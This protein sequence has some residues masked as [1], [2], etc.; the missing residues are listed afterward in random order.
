MNDFAVFIL[1]HGR[2][3]NVLTYATLKRLGYTGWIY[4]IVDDLDPKK[5]EYI[6][7]YG[8]EVVVFSKKEVG[9]DVGDNFNDM[10]GVVYA[11]N[12]SFDIAKDLRIQ[13][14]IQ[15]DDDYGHFQFRYDGNL[16]YNPR[17]VKDLDSV[18]AALLEFYKSAPIHSVCIA[19]GGDYIGGRESANAKGISTKRKAM[20]SF[21]CGTDRPFDFLGRINED[22]NTYVQHGAAG[23]VFLTTNQLSLE[24]TQTQLA[25]GGLTEQYLDIGTYVK[26]FYSVMYQPSSVKINVLTDRGN[27]RIHHR[28]SWKNTTP[29]ILRDTLKKPLLKNSAT[30]NAG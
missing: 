30:N 12:A 4:L 16:D 1:T 26:S 21:L 2:P 22:V 6:H 10:R 7:R 20:N 28:V 25:S 9:F 11:R 3:N 18:F 27:P 29:M 24:Q 5:D 23:K 19:Q 15:L 14:F 17:V 13:Y 8:D